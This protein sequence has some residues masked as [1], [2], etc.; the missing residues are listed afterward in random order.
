MANNI[1]EQRVRVVMLIIMAG[2][3]FGY[4]TLLFGYLLVDGT[5]AVL[6]EDRWLNLQLVAT[7]PTLLVSLASCHYRLRLTK[8]Q[9]VRTHLLLLVVLVVYFTVQ[10]GLLRI[11]Q[12][13]V[14][15]TFQAF[16]RV[17]SAKDEQRA[18][19][20]MT[21]EWQ[22]EHGVDDV[23]RETANFWA[24]GQAHS[25]YTVRI[26]SYNGRAEVVP[27]ARTSW[28]FRP[29]AG[30]SWGFKKVDG[31]WYLAPANINYYMAF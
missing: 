1:E 4:G 7:L 5:N 3:A 30:A 13:Q 29:S 8:Q 27:N 6:L 25:V 17:Y 20:L 2:V 19:A 12:G 9:L 21:P 31:V 28:W 14:L 10:Y 24:L 18:Y 15:A 11:E 16:R 26:H 22:Q 23:F